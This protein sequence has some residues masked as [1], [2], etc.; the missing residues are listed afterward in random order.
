MSAV[1]F[2]LASAVALAIVLAACAA[3]RR[4]D[5]APV[6]AS[7]LAAPQLEPPRAA[8]H[9]YTVTS[10]QGDRVD[11]YYW[12]RDDTRSKPEVLDYLARENA[13]I[14]AQLAH[15][16]PL[17]EQIYAEMV[18]R[19]DPN[20]YTVP[21]RKN[22]YWYY[23]RFE[24]G[25]DFP[26]F[27]RREGTLDAPEQV[28]VDGNARAVGHEFYQLAGLEVSTDGRQLA[29]TEDDVGR[30]LYTLHF[31]DLASGV[32]YPEVVRGVEA[33]IAWAGDNKTV[34]YVEKDPETLLGE[35]VKRHVLGTDPALDV[36]VYEEHDHAFSMNVSRSRSDAYLFIKLESTAATEQRF[37]RADD[38]NFSFQPILPRAR[39]HEYQAEDRAGEWIL[40]TNDRAPNFRMVAAPMARVADRGAWRDLVPARADAFVHDFATFSHYLAVGE[41]SGGLRRVRVMDIDVGTQA[42]I[43]ADEPA[44]TM[45]LSD[46]PEVDTT[47][48]RYQYTSLTTPSSIYEYDLL[49][50][51]RRLLKQDNVL[52]G[53]RAS[54]YK[55]EFLRAPARD[56]A[57]IPVSIV[58]RRDAVPTGKPR[59][60]LVLGYGAYGSSKEPSFDPARVSLLDRGFAV[61]IA[62]VRGGSE[63][64]RAWYEQG[65]LLNKKNTFNDF[66]D[67]TEFLVK[68][69]RADPQ[70]VFAAGRSAGGLLMGAVLN[71]RPDL[72]R[73]MIAVVPFVDAV[74][75]GLDE[76][77]PLTSGEFDEWGDPKQKAYYDYMLS[78]S[79][80]DNV[81]AQRYPALLV[82]TGLW[83]SQVQYYEP[84]KWVARLRAR[85]LGDAPLLF[86]TDMSAGHGGKA[87][88]FEH[89]RE[90]ALEYA[91]ILDQLAPRGGSATRDIARTGKN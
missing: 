3:P 24:P 55:T 43:E 67:A 52:G 11:E 44:F 58:Y 21:Q 64:G 70:G 33:E 19:L 50:G 35:R 86:K 20:D 72:Y 71:M 22:G 88:R 12:L 79:P 32:E 80:Y 15:T 18:A 56:G 4:A 85:K 61:A 9:P 2:R 31:K 84:A 73:G 37:A 68:S 76:T 26:L 6:A 75:T 54:R 23:H 77:I 34:L 29:W 51:T 48:L 1:P 30:R 90:T 27:G 13:Y 66:I 62:H 10:P 78:Y 5:V 46:N 45:S 53:Y 25:R 16:R 65:R 17:Q 14:D 83:D 59:P 82:T 57:S 38:P 87:G 69:G 81:S 91:F 63:L 47:K 39:D 7:T 36:L 42:L 60:T 89:L 41:R 40:R 74:T 8:V 49:D 28:L